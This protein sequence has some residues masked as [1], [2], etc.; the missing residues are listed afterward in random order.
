MP[1]RL[2]HLVRIQSTI[3]D[4]TAALVRMGGA[5][6]YATC[7]LLDAENRG[8]VDAFLQRSPDWRLEM[9]KTFTPIDGGD[10][11][12]AAILRKIA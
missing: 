11:F 1:D 3:L 5:L 9:T 8:Q 7:S 4:E 6:A 12:F 2:D 10:G